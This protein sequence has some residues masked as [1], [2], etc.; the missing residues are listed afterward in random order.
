MFCFA[1]CLWVIASL[2][3]ATNVIRLWNVMV[4]R[5]MRVLIERELYVVQKM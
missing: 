5:E 1:G 2:R 3:V 4:E